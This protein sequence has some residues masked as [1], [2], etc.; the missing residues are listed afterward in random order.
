VLLLLRRVGIS[1]VERVPHAGVSFG[2]IPHMRRQGLL[3]GDRGTIPTGRS[4]RRSGGDAAVLEEGRA[5]VKMRR[6][7]RKTV[8]VIVISAFGFLD[9]I[10]MKANRFLRAGHDPES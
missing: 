9:W 5:R 4:Q 10:S 7:L 6:M 2:E 8:I 3:R 1:R